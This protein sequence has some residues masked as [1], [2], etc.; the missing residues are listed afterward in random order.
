MNRQMVST[1]TYLCTSVSI[2][3]KPSSNPHKP[4]KA[5][6]MNADQTLRGV[7]SDA[8]DPWRGVDLQILHQRTYNMVL[9]K[10]ALIPV[11]KY[12]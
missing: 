11:M 2:S 9:S 1:S 3:S 8:K 4:T 6:N 7:Q 12:H 5:L 10:N